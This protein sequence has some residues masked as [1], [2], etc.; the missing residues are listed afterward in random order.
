MELVVELHAAIGD[1]HEKKDTVAFLSS[2]DKTKAM[3]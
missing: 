3:I 2:V 1:D